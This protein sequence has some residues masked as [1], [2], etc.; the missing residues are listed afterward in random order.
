M[1]FGVGAEG[2]VCIFPMATHSPLEALSPP[3]SFLSTRPSLVGFLT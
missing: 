2:D 3:L 1:P